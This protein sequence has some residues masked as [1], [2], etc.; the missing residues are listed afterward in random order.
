MNHKTWVKFLTIPHQHEA[1]QASR[2]FQQPQYVTSL[3]HHAE[4]MPTNAPVASTC[5]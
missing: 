1:S 2:F 5:D 4:H 3:M